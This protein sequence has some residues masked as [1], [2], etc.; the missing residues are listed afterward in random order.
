MQT[1]KKK[2]W[3]VRYENGQS[4][5]PVLRET[6]GGSRLWTLA[7]I[8]EVIPKAFPDQPNVVFKAFRDHQTIIGSPHGLTALEFAREAERMEMGIRTTADM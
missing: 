7:E 2:I 6:E 5:D 3:V 4:G 8:V 1:N